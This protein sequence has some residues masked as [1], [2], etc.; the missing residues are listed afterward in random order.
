MKSADVVG[1]LDKEVRSEAR[2]ASYRANNEQV[3]ARNMTMVFEET[4]TLDDGLHT[5]ISIKFPLHD[6]DGAA[7]GVCG[8]ATDITERKRAQADLARERELSFQREKLA[9]LG[10]LLA[11]VAHELN[12]PLSVVVARAVLLEEQGN[13][14][15]QTAAAKI[16][17]AAE[18]CAHRAHLP[19]DGAPAAAATRPGGD[20]GGGRRGPGHRQLRAAFGQHRRADRPADDLPPIDADADQLHRC[21][22]TC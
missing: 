12:N 14:A 7:Y 2:A 1:R 19:R 8:I 20:R 6:A 22:S 5:Y 18:R 11:G 9:A 13:L 3:L 16:R 4:L 21:C 15:T 17:S 10:S